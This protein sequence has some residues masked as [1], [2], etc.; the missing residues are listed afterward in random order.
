MKIADVIFCS[1][2]VFIARR[3]CRL[4]SIHSALPGLSTTSWCHSS[5]YIP[6]I[7][8]CFVI[9]KSHNH[10]LS[11]WMPIE[12]SAKAMK[13]VITFNKNCY[14]LFLPITFITTA[15]T[16]LL[17]STPLCA[18]LFCVRS[19]AIDDSR[20]M[21]RQ[22]LHHGSQLDYFY[23]AFMEN[24]NNSIHTNFPNR[25]SPFNGKKECFSNF[26]SFRS[27]WDGGKLVGQW[28]ERRGNFVVIRVT[29]FYGGN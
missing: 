6:R 13:F 24:W 28:S 5:I 17:C 3:L 10:C 15:L 21:T 22:H 1:L 16:T 11:H 12:K 8:P 7:R 18:S 25:V 4:F 20:T 2:I 27:W 9:L 14:I 23:Y 29:L 19:S 26:L